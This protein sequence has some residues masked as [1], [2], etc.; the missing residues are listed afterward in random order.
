VTSMF[1]LARLASCGSRG[2][3]VALA[4]TMAII[5]TPDQRLRVF[6]SS[7]MN[8]LAAERAAARRAIENLRLS[9]ILFEGEVDAAAPRMGPAGLDRAPNES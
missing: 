1:A 2:D 3:D 4:E 5:S 6:V 8:E 7:A 9:P